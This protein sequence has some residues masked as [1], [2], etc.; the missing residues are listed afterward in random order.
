MTFAGMCLKSA[1]RNKTRLSLTLAGT[2]VA[3]L[4][5]TAL[6]TTSLAWTQ[7][8]EW[9]AKDRVA[10]RHKVT[11]VMT[12]PQKYAAQIAQVP[13]VKA[14]SWANWFGA[15]NPN[16]EKEFF[17]SMAVDHTTLFEVFPELVVDQAAK[18]TFLHD[19]QGA[20]VGDVIARK[21]NWKVGDKVTLLGTI[22][23][24]DWTFNVAGIYTTSRKSMDR[25]SFFFR[26]DY[27]NENLPPE[28]RDQIGWTMSRID[29]PAESANIS[30]AI[31]KIFEEQDP[32][33][34]SMSERAM[35]ASFLGMFSSILGA[36]DIVS[37]VILAIMALILGNTIAMGARERVKEYGTM[38]AIGFLP[39][40]VAMY[41]LGEG[42]FTGL[43]G[44]L[45]GI[46]LAYPLVQMGLGGFLEENM[47]GFFP[48]YRIHPMTVAIALGAAIVL[49][50][51]AAI[52]PALN[53]SRLEVSSAL[54]KVA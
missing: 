41:V 37:G 4:A 22:Y 20:I 28:R 47:G 11:F 51:G 27:L 25:S 54:R 31:D 34:L 14:T 46:A 53:A 48:Y 39:K 40:H 7:G 44:G 3:I 33:T 19:K 2:A 5:F 32:Q 8:Q 18:D 15:K 42:G 29:N 9:A 6:R 30:A 43:L 16:A 10:T 26:W 38:R 24:G 45:V 49:G 52:L 21:F 13:G 23:P 1:M 50:A 17:A 36:L 12:L 35:N